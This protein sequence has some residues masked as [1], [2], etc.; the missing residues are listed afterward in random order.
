MATDTIIK[1]N[2]HQARSARLIAEPPLNTA[3]ETDHQMTREKI[4]QIDNQI[5][6]I[7]KEQ[8]KRTKRTNKQKEENKHNKRSKRAAE[9]NILKSDLNTHIRK[10]KR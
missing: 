2:E 6:D 5:I 3:L 8:E 7:T 1:T 9:E 4:N 10:H